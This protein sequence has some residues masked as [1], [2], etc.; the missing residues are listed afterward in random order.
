MLETLISALVMIV[1]MFIPDLADKWEDRLASSKNIKFGN[2]YALLDDVINNLTLISSTKATKLI[3]MLSDK[4]NAFVPVGSSALTEHITQAKQVALDKLEKATKNQTAVSLYSDA[5]NKL[6]SIYEGMSTKQKDSEAGRALISQMN[7][8]VEQAVNSA[9]ELDP[10]L[11]TDKIRK[12]M[13]AKLPK[14]HNPR[15]VDNDDLKLV[16]Q[17]PSLGLQ[18]LRNKLERTA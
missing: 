10:D 13:E 17:A 6:G 3:N 2:I 11:D 4:I 16:D 5:A 7:K 14:P 9:K 15:G 1:A 18:N 12:D 8:D